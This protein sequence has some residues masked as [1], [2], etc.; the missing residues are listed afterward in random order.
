MTASDQPDA[1]APLIRSIV[2]G[3]LDNNVL[4]VADRSGPSGH[5]G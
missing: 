5:G 1:A 2:A 4:L 3:P